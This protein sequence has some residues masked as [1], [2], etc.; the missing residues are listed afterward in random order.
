MKKHNPNKISFTNQRNIFLIIL[1]LSL[2]ASGCRPSG[3]PVFETDIHEG[4]D[5]LILEFGENMPPDDITDKVTFP[6]GIEMRNK[7]TENIEYGY[8]TLLNFYPDEMVLKDESKTKSFSIEGKQLYNSEGG[9]ELLTYTIE[10]K[11][12]PILGKKESNFLFKAVAC[13]KYR[14]VAGINVCI[15]PKKFGFSFG[16]DACEIE[17]IETSQGQGGPLAVTKIEQN[18]IPQTDDKTQRITYTGVYKILIENKGEGYLSNPVE[19]ARPCTESYKKEN[20]LKAENIMVELS[21]NLLTCTPIAKVKGSNSFFTVCNADLGELQDA[22]DTPLT[23]TIDYG[24]I[25]PEVEKEVFVKVVSADE[26]CQA[27]KCFDNI[28]GVCELYGGE[29]TKAS[30]SCNL[31]QKCC[32]ESVESCRR[33]YG[34]VNGDGT[35]EYECRARN[36]CQADTILE[37]FCP[38]DIDNVCCKLGAA[39]EPVPLPPGEQVLPSCLSEPIPSNTY[40]TH[41]EALAVL[42]A[43]GISVTSTN[44]CSDI[45]NR[46]CTSLMGI[47][48]S[49]ITKI[50]EIKNGCPGCQVVVTGGTEIGHDTH[51]VG[52]PIVD[53]HW[54]R[55]LALLL[56]A[57]VSKQLYQIDTIC[58]TAEDAQIVDDNGNSVTVR[59]NCGY[60]EPV[61][62]LHVEFK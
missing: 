26:A 34:D 45:C 57:P 59:F 48:V 58:T 41:E 21:G 55:N 5:G 7:G 43:N 19:Y 11:G 54:D 38:G 62:H 18:I 35:I 14:M 20:D 36:T 33:N 28:N 30:S 29:N 1:A 22:Y 32:Y 9:Y 15:K 8:L 56:A 61:Q 17:D 13:Y 3:Q 47:P 40:A 49:T 6:I 46:Y 60:N 50:I 44:S 31:N 39:P 37:G 42:Q 27:E 2:L 23:V 10:N 53:L 52:K 4:T 12:L 51:G 25:S 16:E 24:Y